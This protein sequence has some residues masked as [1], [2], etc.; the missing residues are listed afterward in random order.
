[1]EAP[2]D[3]AVF[4]GA[5]TLPESVAIGDL[6]G[7]QDA[8]L[9]VVNRGGHYQTLFNNGAGVFG[10]AV[11]HNNVWPSD[12]YTVDVRLSDLDRDGD[13]DI[14]AAYTSLSGSVSI[15][16]NNGNGTFAAP[17]NFDS[18]YSTQGLTIGDFNGDLQWDV[19]GMTNCFR[20]AVM[21]NDGNAA[22][23]RTG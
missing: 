18:C 3:N 7:D 22:L 9:V 12:N 8:D 13:I 10:A 5:G 6:D 21:L 20:A 4:Y 1:A 14:V 17:V 19:A 11:A 15:L 23:H 16:R 2:F